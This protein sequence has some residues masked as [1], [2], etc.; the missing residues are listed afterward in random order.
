M[1]TNYHLGISKDAFEN[2]NY[3]LDPDLNIQEVFPHF[4]DYMRLF[5]K[6]GSEW[7][8]DR[9]PRYYNQD[10]LKERV[11]SGK[12]FLLKKFDEVKGYCLAID[13]SDLTSQFNKHSVEEIENFG[14]FPEFNAQGF[15]KTFLPL[16]F[17]ELFKKHDYIYLSSRST[18]HEKVIPFYQKLGMKT[19]KTEI[20]EDDLHETPPSWSMSIN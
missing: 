19:L 1:F 12:L 5:K 17:N 7:G 3:K 15:G 4:E 8:W 6:V 9:R 2:F 11:D 16:I 10:S 18:N 14:L 13:R 20:L